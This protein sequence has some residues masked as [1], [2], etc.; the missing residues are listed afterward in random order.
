MTRTLRGAGIKRKKKVL[1]PPLF[2]RVLKN[3][4]L[5]LGKKG[6][7]VRESRGVGYMNK[8]RAC[9]K[10]TERP[11]YCSD[12]CQGKGW[13][14]HNR[15]RYLAGKRLYQQTHKKEVGEYNRT[16]RF[17]NKD[18]VSQYNKTYKEKR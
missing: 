9:G 10:P 8:C 7:W 1:S 13:K 5:R 4:I 14:L 12:S 2:F 6:E 11:M 16:W 18:K 15:E 17:A 3:D